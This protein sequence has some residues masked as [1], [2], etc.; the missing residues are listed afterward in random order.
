MIHKEYII[1]K[2]NILITKNDSFV[3]KFYIFKM[4]TISINSFIFNVMEENNEM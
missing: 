1:S 3:E 2:N 4:F